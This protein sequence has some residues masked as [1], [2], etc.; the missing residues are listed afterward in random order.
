MKKK[1][2]TIENETQE[3]ILKEALKVEREV[4]EFGI[5]SNPNQLKEKKISELNEIEKLEKQLQ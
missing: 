4:R 1:T 3:K 2:I 5:R